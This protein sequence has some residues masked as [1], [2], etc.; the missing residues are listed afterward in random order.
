MNRKKSLETLKNHPY[1]GPMLSKL[2]KCDQNA[3]ESFVLVHC[4]DSKAEWEK[5]VNA[6]AMAPHRSKK[7]TLVC[8]I[9][10]A[11]I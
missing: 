7:I 10:T 4:D 6:L 11:I 5:A 3:I 2:P 1:Y 8:D 9:L